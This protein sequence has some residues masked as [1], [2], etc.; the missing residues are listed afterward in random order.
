MTTS[1]ATARARSTAEIGRTDHPAI[2]AR[3]GMAHSAQ[4]GGVA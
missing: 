3:P 4:P 1:A 2:D